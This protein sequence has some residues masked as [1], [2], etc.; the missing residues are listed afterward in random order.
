MFPI[1]IDPSY[2]DISIRPVAI[3]RDSNDLATILKKVAFH[4][5][6][7]LQSQEAI[8]ENSYQVLLQMPAYNAYILSHLE[9][10]LFILEMLPM[11]RTEFGQYYA[12]E[13]RDYF[14]Q[15]NLSIDDSLT[16]T[17]VQ[18]LRASLDGIFAN[19]E[20]NVR[21]LIFPL[22]YSEPGSLLNNILEET[23]FF[24]LQKKTDPRSPI[25]YAYPKTA[26]VNDL[27]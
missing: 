20:I 24:I 9:T 13:P 18:A 19:P 14:L 16:D 3:P 7:H 11:N 27:K 15:L 4:P 25:F 5:I 6:W 26:I 1:D 2:Q 17:A 23:G 12:E 8:A 22:F 10:T 21:R